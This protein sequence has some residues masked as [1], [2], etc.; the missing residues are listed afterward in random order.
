MADYPE[1]QA[2]H[3]TRLNL[4]KYLSRINPPSFQKEERTR[5]TGVKG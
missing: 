4:K 3:E 2:E 1:S 5:P